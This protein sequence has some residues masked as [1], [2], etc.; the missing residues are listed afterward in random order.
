MVWAWIAVDYRTNFHSFSHCTVTTRLCEADIR[1]Y[2]GLKFLETMI[3]VLFFTNDNEHVH[4]DLFVNKYLEINASSYEIVIT[5][6]DLNSIE[7]VIAYAK[8][9]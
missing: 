3:L 5:I 8:T 9:I 1:K 2:Y 7:H 4:K 6:I